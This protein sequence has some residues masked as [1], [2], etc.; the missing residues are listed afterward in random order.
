VRKPDEED[1]RRIIDR[2]TYLKGYEIKLKEPNRLLFPG[3]KS[4]KPL[5]LGDVPAKFPVDHFECYPVKSGVFHL[6]Q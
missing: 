5:S 2:T 1:G 6:P 4:K 3:L